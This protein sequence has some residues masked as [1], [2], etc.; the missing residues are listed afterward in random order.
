MNNSVVIP[1][2]LVAVSLGIVFHRQIYEVV[3][4]LWGCI[5]TAYGYTRLTEEDLQ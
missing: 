1:V 3:D 5:T 2:A 4:G